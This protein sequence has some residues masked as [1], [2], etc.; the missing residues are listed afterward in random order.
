MGR[1]RRSDTPKDKKG[2]V[3]RAI[4]KEMQIT[5]KTLTGARVQYNVE[6]E[7]TVLELKRA[8]QEKEGIQYDQIRLIYSGRQLSDETSLGVYNIT[9]GATIFFVLALRG[10]GLLI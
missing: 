1:R 10:G 4:I 3:E 9:A 6:P 8:L 5:V 7:T 2:I